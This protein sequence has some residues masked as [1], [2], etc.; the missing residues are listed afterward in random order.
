MPYSKLACLSLIYR[1]SMKGE[2]SLIYQYVVI[3]KMYRCVISKLLKFVWSGNI[4]IKIIWLNF[5][6]DCGTH[7]M[8]SH[9][10]LQDVQNKQSK[11]SEYRNSRSFSFKYVSFS[12]I[13]KK[14]FWKSYISLHS[15]LKFSIMSQNGSFV[16]QKET[17]I[18]L[19]VSVL[20]TDIGKI[21]ILEL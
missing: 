18:K 1:K 16:S 19:V 5:R 9:D 12:H 17:V 2:R 10:P 20:L 14:R 21:I 4:H 13:T 11:C 8:M 6:S 7:A 15:S 3:I